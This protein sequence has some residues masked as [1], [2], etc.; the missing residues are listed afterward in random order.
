M[1]RELLDFTAACADLDLNE[2]PSPDS[3][4]RGFEL[5]LERTNLPK[6]R[7]IHP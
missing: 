7:R 4:F 3:N 1:W 5:R 2:I 6:V